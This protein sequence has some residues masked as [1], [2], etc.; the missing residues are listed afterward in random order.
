MAGRS[1]HC[2]ERPANIKPIILKPGTTRVT[3][4]KAIA[5]ET[6]LNRLKVMRF[7][8]N[9]NK[10][11]TGFAKREATVNPAPAITMVSSP[12]SKCNPDAICETR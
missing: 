9:N 1:S 6:H 12:F 8:G 3:K 10:L 2:D 7:I 11:M 4:Y 5:E